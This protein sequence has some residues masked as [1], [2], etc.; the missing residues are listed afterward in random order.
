MAERSPVM[1]ARLL[2]KLVHPAFCSCGI[3]TADVVMMGVRWERGGR[4]R[5]RWVIES[6]WGKAR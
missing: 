4:Y 5:C 3:S 1:C 6:R 2:M